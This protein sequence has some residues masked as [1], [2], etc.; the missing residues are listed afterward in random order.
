[1]KQLKV[2]L[3]T[4]RDISM[5]FERSDSGIR[6]WVHK[7]EFPFHKIGRNQVVYVLEEVLEWSKET[8]HPIINKHVPRKFDPAK[9]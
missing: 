2:T 1:M 7:F 9:R 6:R 5:M 4:M 3:I 8:N